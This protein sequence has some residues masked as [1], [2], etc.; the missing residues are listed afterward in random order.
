MGWA[1]A[2][3]RTCDI[4]L[5]IIWCTD[6]HSLRSCLCAECR[7]LACLARIWPMNL[8]AI[9]SLLEVRYSTAAPK[10]ANVEDH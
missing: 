9:D 1:R 10:G 3:V 6:G 4:C 2:L 7:H 8:F 5:R